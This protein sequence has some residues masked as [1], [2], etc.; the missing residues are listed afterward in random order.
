MTLS[1][2]CSMWRM[3][4]LVCYIVLNVCQPRGCISE[5]RQ[6][7]QD[8]LTPLQT[9]I[10]SLS[11]CFVSTRETLLS[12]SVFAAT[13]SEY[14]HVGVSLSEGPAAGGSSGIVQRPGWPLRLS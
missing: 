5:N 13:S 6:L 2:A 12:G 9:H 4:H 1:K 7:N 10:L 3:K 11:P 8:A 14:L